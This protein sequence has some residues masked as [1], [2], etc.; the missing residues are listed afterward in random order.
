MGIIVA[1]LPIACRGP[2]VGSLVMVALSLLLPG[3]DGYGSPILPALGGVWQQYAC[4][5]MA[6]L[7]IRPVF[8]SAK[9]DGCN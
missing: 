3:L 5:L 4:I 6:T 9:D 7:Y 1:L 2:A 8:F